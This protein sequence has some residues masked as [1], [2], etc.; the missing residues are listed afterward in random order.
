M[1]KRGRKRSPNGDADQL[2]LVQT[3]VS[4]EAKTLL[5]KRADGLAISLAAYVRQVLYRDVG[6]MKD[7]DNT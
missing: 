6:L 5:D 3:R 4:Q 2:E 7:K 1:A